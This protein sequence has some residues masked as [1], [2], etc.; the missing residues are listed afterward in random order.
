MNI[1]KFSPGKNP[2]KEINV[3]V[4]VPQGSSVKYEIDK[5]SG[6]LLVDRFLYTAVDYPFNYGFIPSTRAGDGDPA[7]VILISSLAVVPG[8]LVA[9]HPIG[10][11]KMEDES[12]IDNKIIAVPLKK[13]DPQF[14]HVHDITDI[15]DYIRRKIKNFFKDYKEL[16]PKKWVKIGEFLGE[17]YALEEIEKS[18]LP[19][20]AGSRP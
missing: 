20:V 9:A 5:N 10:L 2:P 3:V 8:S 6:A 1:S 11:L 15:N 4:E 12:G 19:P 17:K 16:E 18:L 14:D 7:D 13:V